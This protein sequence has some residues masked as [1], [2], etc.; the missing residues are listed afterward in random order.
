LKSETPCLL[1][2]SSSNDLIGLFDFADVNAFLTLAASRHADALSARANSI[3]DAAK[4]GH[5]PVKLVSNFSDK[6]P[7]EILDG[8]E[9]SVLDLLRLFS[10]GVHRGWCRCSI[11]FRKLDLQL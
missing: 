7:L 3:I 5:V 9:K 8:A 2:T 10:R 4:K 1:V 11:Y 6:N